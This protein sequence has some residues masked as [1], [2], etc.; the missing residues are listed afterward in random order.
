LKAGAYF[1]DESALGN[2]AH[3]LM[4]FLSLNNIGLQ[5]DV[6]LIACEKGI[7]AMANNGVI[8]QFDLSVVI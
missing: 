6:K 1:R 7:R 8:L 3:E 2:V 5:G 4:L